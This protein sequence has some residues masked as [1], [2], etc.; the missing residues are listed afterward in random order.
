MPKAEPLR[1]L[2][3]GHGLQAES[4][5]PQDCDVPANVFC[6]W[7]QFLGTV[8]WPS[9][10][11][12]QYPGWNLPELLNSSLPP[13]H[14]TFF[15]VHLHDDL[16]SLSLYCLN[17]AVVRVYRLTARDGELA[18][19]QQNFAFCTSQVFNPAGLRSWPRCVSKASQN[20][21]LWT[22]VLSVMF[23]ISSIFF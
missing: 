17:R 21:R 5:L 4:M 16:F 11:H 2:P 22:L 3:F 7:R 12:G 10:L 23:I 13:P 9:D 15:L 14:P 8:L 6:R 1:T 20:S 19:I 18:L